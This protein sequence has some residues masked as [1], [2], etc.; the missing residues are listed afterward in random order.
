[1]VWLQY[2]KKKVAVPG[3]A[4]YQSCIKFWSMVEHAKKIFWH[5]HTLHQHI[6]L[7]NSLP[8]TMNHTQL[9]QYLQ[10][11]EPSLLRASDWRCWWFSKE[12]L[13]GILSIHSVKQKSIGPK[14]KV[15]WLRVATINW[16]VLL[17][18][19]LCICSVSLSS[20][21]YNQSHRVYI[22]RKQQYIC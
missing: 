3:K 9:L 20:I 21:H 16:V 14:M 10:T 18:P 8:I 2:R 22:N 12:L 11:K 15:T 5:Y 6:S 7:E 1:M 17:S 13:H 19:H 4:D